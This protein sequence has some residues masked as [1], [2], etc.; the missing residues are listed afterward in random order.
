[1]IIPSLFV[2]LGTTGTDILMEL[3]RLIFEEFGE[4][5]LPV[6]KMIALE[7]NNNKGTTDRNINIDYSV[8]YH[9]I[10]M[11]HIGI[12]STAH[13]KQMLDPHSPTF[14]S[15]LKEW[16]DPDILRNMSYSAGA[17][18][19]RMA[20]RLCLWQSW[21]T[22]QERLTRALSSLRAKENKD[23]TVKI[24]ESYCVKKNIQMPVDPIGS[25]PNITILGTFCGGTCS[26]IF[27]DIAYLLRDIMR[28][29]ELNPHVSGIFTIPDQLMARQPT[30]FKD[31]VNCF[32]ALF[33]L[34]YYHNTKRKVVSQNNKP[35]FK[36]RPILNGNP[37]QDSDPPLD[38][39]RVVSP[40][41][42]NVDGVSPMLV[43]SD[44]K[45]NPEPLNFMIALNLFMDVGNQTYLA[46]DG[47]RANVVNSPD[48]AK[49]PINGAGHSQFMSAFGLSALWYPKYKIVHAVAIQLATELIDNW[50]AQSG[51]QDL[52]AAEQAATGFKVDGL[53]SSINLESALKQAIDDNRQDLIRTDD[54]LL[55]TAVEKLKA[56]NGM[57][58]LDQLKPGGF[59][60]NQ[61]QAILQGNANLAKIHLEN[62]YSSMLNQLSNNFTCINAIEHSLKHLDGILSRKI[63][64][65]PQN[66]PFVSGVTSDPDLQ[67]VLKQTR[68]IKRD[69][70]LYLLFVRADAIEQKK[71]NYIQKYKDVLNEKFRQIREF[72][73]RQVYED[74]RCYL[75]IEPGLG[76]AKLFFFQET[77]WQQFSRLNVRFKEANSHLSNEHDKVM[78]IQNYPSISLAGDYKEDIN[79]ILAEERQRLLGNALTRT[80]PQIIGA[81]GGKNLVDII[82]KP[83]KEVAD[84]L[85][86]FFQSQVNLNMDSRIDPLKQP[87]LN[88]ANLKQLFLQSSQPMMQIE[89]IPNP[90]A[91]RNPDI[92]TG[93]DPGTIQK[94][95]TSLGITDLS[96]LS[97]DYDNFVAVYRENGPFSLDQMSIY[98][99]WSQLYSSYDIGCPKHTRSQGFPRP[100]PP[101]PTF[102]DWLKVAL[103]FNDE[104][105]IF[106]VDSDG[107]PYRHYTDDNGLKRKF[108][109]DPDSPSYDDFIQKKQNRTDLIYTIQGACQQIGKERFVELVNDHINKRF[110]DSKGDDA[111]RELNFFTQRI[112]DL[113]GEQG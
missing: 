80:L 91:V 86:A 67:R 105:G 43:G 70:W 69:K 39:V 111:N 64:E 25:N 110:S 100:T 32:S 42:R 36:I 12:P 29:Q 63:D 21:N 11:I 48:F 40:T 96:K 45:I 66:T 52:E 50:L 7:T 81:E 77:L 53:F 22:V 28:S 60:F 79:N 93:P 2:G 59:V 62:F 33:E 104:L 108:V 72:H 78:Q 99:S 51:N 75:G 30:Y 95:L 83:G 23:E 88:T 10:E 35:L 1:M 8:P 56:P 34:D 16:L 47:V 103:L 17:G 14:H 98:K 41:G 85:L 5:G 73:I 24:L 13:I 44:G 54:L 87:N 106:N 55:D 112:N 68:N 76:K 4:P 46:K 6:I 58:F 74:L 57:T 71:E 20:G 9:K 37:I 102:Y 90:P 65:L 97:S 31:A 84:S 61:Y 89:I 94:C 15:G 101:D 26:G 19:I 49:V 113:Y 92:I 109:T 27:I 38:A 3:R 82:L 18:Q 107:Q